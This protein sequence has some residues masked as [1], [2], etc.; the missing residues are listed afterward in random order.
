MGNQPSYYDI[1]FVPMKGREPEHYAAPKEGLKEVRA[2]GRGQTS[3]LVLV[4]M[5][6]VERKYPMPTVDAMRH[7][8]FFAQ[9][10]SI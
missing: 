8:L 1:D 4:Y 10:L 5:N 2:S 6:G 3:C 7:W 9:R